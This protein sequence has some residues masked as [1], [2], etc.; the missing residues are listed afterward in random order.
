MSRVS[1]IMRCK[2]S[3]WVIGQTLTALFC[4]SYKDFELIVVD[5]GST[6][7][8]LEIVKQYPL[9]LIQIE[10]TEY[11][12][13]TVLNMAIEQSDSELI[14]FLNADAVPLRKDTL[15]KLID[16]FDDDSVQADFARQIPRPEADTWVKRDYAQSFPDSNETPPG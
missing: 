13:G 4:Q 5:S 9:R 14:V 6:D 16:A 10:P 12:P 7:R 11:Y 15:Q 3:D 1:V 2:N 8:T